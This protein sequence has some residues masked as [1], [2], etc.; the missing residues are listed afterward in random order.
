MQSEQTNPFLRIGTRGSPL[1]LVQARH[2]RSLLAKEHNVGETEIKIVV[3]KTDGDRT[4]SENLSLKDI[5]GKG[6]FS[7][8][9]EAALLAGDVDIG[10]HSAKDMATALPDGL[11]MEIYLEREDTRDAFICQSAST[12]E[13][14]AEGATVGTSSLR[15]AAQLR[16]F[17]P[18]LKIIEFRGNVDTR[19]QK[20]ANG[21][22]DAT[23]LAVAGLNRLGKSDVA[24]GL[25]DP[26]TFPPAPA[27]GAIGI[28]TRTDDKRTR[29]LIATLNHGE[30][31]EAV[32]AE[33][34]MLATLD[35]S[36]RTPIG[37]LS[38]RHGE[39]LTMSAQILSP[40]GSQCFAGHI[41]GAAQDAPELGRDLGQKL[42]AA[43]G[44][45]FM[46]RLTQSQSQQ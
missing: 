21:V 27:Q 31:N 11:E 25:L 3:I 5:G 19:L 20:L 24:T 36:C 1:A 8:E 15:R 2:V 45:D 10:V 38:E 14:L 32:T 6:L 39:Q 26:E 4:Q 17:R 9:I 34:A 18:D 40:D 35:G 41:E 28:E 16:H 43:A 12:L 44:E 29:R 22:A 37:V 23:L 33:R 13:E 46:A 42:I 7:K 30:T